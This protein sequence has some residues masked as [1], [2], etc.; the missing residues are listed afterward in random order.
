MLRETDTYYLR[1][2][3]TKEI[4]DQRSSSNM[5]SSQLEMEK[6]TGRR[7][8]SVGKFLYSGGTGA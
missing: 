4:T 5:I 1:R 3:F 2:S 8:G 6:R 7:Q